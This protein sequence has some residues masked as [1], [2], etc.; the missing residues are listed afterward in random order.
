VLRHSIGEPRQDPT[1]EAMAEVGVRTW[2][3]VPSKPQQPERVGTG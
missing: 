3:P 1:I 2:P